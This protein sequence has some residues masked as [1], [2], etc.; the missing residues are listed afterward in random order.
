MAQKNRKE[1]IFVFLK[2]FVKKTS[3]IYYNVQKRADDI[4]RIGRK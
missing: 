2:N 4:L 1:I 3:I